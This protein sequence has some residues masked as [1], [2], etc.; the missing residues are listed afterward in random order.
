MQHHQV[1]GVDDILVM[2]QPVA[3]LDHPDGV[4]APQPHPAQHDVLAPFLT[5]P[6]RVDD[7]E[8]RKQRLG[9]GR[10]HIDE[11]EPAVFRHRVGG[12]P[13]IHRLAEL[14]CFAWHVDALALG[15]VEPAVVAAA[16]PLLLDAAPF[17]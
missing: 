4:V 17:E 15:I 16:Q 9:A 8:P 5:I 10:A 11:D 12:L 13:H 14:L 2:L 3:V 1:I 6:G 7:V